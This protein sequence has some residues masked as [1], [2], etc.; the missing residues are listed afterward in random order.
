MK[1]LWVRIRVAYYK[2]LVF[3]IRVRAIMRGFFGW[4]FDFSEKPG[5][6]QKAINIILVLLL[7]LS[8]VAVMS[9]ILG[10][11]VGRGVLQDWSYFAALGIDKVA[12]LSK[13]VGASIF[14]G[15]V[16]APL[17]EEPVFRGWPLV[18]CS[19]A[20]PGDRKILLY[21]VLLASAVFG[22][23]H[24]GVV[25]IIFQGIGGLCLSYLYL[26][27]GNCIWSAMIMHSLYNLVLI[28]TSKLLMLP[29]LLHMV[30]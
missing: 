19:R 25:N 10:M 26:K 12:L 4:V 23:L 24:G 20:F 3:L 27:N 22:V 15:C 18:T 11:T 17:W 28:L 13:S 9:T 21:W 29:F 7:E 14:F 8:W 2:F 16:I 6:K 5:W 30:Y 1:R